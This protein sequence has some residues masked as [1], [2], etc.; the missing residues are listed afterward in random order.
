MSNSMKS[1]VEPTKTGKRKG[2]R[3]VSTLTPSQ[4]ARKRA[5]DREAQ[6]A[7]RARTKEHIEN[8][9]KEIEELRSQQGRDQTIQTLLRKNKTL[10]DELR[11]IRDGMG[12]RTADAGEQYQPMFHGSSP[13]NS[14]V[15][16]QS[17]PNYPLMQNMTYGNIPDATDPWPTTVPCSLSSTASSPSSSAATDE[18]GGN[19]LAT[20]APSTVFD[21][22]SMPRTA[23]SPTMPTLSCV[24]SDGAFEDVK[25][26]FGCPQIGMVPI[27]PT[28][29]MQPWSMYPMQQYQPAPTP[30]THGHQMSQI[31]RCQF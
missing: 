1:T 17:A 25:P 5:N 15:F 24:S 31:A 3:S 14:H 10:E 11:R 27:N 23:R 16:G 29:Q 22:S 18:F 19:Y 12:I 21:R 26:E 4:L 6:R 8:L 13:P 28:Y 20:S 2:T 9:E 7:I 30:I